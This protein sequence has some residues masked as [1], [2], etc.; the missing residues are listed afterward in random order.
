MKNTLSG[1]SAR[2]WFST[3]EQKSTVGRRRDV[4]YDNY[5]AAQTREDMAIAGG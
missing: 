3:C 4:C 5:R 2:R 1:G